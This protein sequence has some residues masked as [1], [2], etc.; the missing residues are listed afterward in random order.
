MKDIKILFEKLKAAEEK[1][2]KAE[3]EYEKAPENEEKEK[4]FD[5]AYKEEF[6]AFEALIGAIVNATDGHIDTQT[7]AAMIRGRRQQLETILEMTK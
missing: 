2:D 7:A 1:A 5:L 3:F 6:K 4:A